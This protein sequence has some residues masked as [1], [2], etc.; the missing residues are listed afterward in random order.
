MLKVIFVD[1]EAQFRKYLHHVIDWEKH[2]FTI[3]GEA[4]NGVEALE[5]VER[6]RPD[7]AFI[8][9]NMPHMNGMDL[10]KQLKA[11]D[12]STFILLVTGH[13]E[14]EYARAAVK[15]GVDDYIL[16]PFDEEELFMALAKVKGAIEK[17]RIE[18]D[19]TNKERLVWKESLLNLLISKE[20]SHD[21]EQIAGQMDLFRLR[22]GSLR[23][24][25]VSVEMDAGHEPWPDPGEIRLRQHIIA[26]LL[27]DLIK[28]EGTAFIFNG[29]ENRVVTLLHFAGEKSDERFSLDGFHKLCAMIK[30]HFGFTVTVGVG[31]SGDGISFIRQS[32]MES[33][34]ALRNK[35]SLRLSDVLPYRDI[36]SRAGNVGFYPSEINE[37]L[38]VQMRLQNEE[39]IQNNLDDIRRYIETK[40]LSSEYIH[41][42]L[43]G[44]VSLCLTY[45]YEIG[46][47]ADDV[48][49][50]GFSPFQEIMRHST[51]DSAFA[52]IQELYL[53]VLRH[54]KSAVRSKSGKTLELAVE[55][56]ASHY[57][58][59]QLKV[60]EVAKQLYIQPRYLLKLFNQAFGMSVSDYILET[61]MKK[62]KELLVSG[63]NLRLTDIAE[64]VG[65]ADSGHFSKSFKKHTGLSPSEYEVTHAK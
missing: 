23:F 26:N 55:Y 48:M 15:I 19:N 50:E 20:Y 63:R 25:V 47:Q 64:M 7:I 31:S 12:P 30:R 18:R 10:A 57:P 5:L 51:L 37:N 40:Q 3:S 9:I 4:K 33:I 35:I 42:I 34:I 21:N 41:M 43:A 53:T 56:I 13:S 1:D 16:K 32:Y 59:S 28:L 60:E 52:W 6:V 54:S 46:K 65:Y 38:I 29:P 22:E 62:A 14:F 49:P 45:I 2:G 39:G 11:R 36:Q 58:D 17:S 27:N 44:L 24:Q 61:R 8:D